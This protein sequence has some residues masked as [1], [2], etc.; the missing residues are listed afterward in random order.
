MQRHT[1]SNR[2][3][4]TA[5]LCF[6]AV[7]IAV[8]TLTSPPTSAFSERKDPPQFNASIDARSGSGALEKDFWACDYAATTRGVFGSEAYLC[9]SNHE[10]L[11][12]TKFRGDFTAM[13]K[14]WQQNKAAE[15]RA[16]AEGGPVASPR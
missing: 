1:G 5:T 11:K 6:C 12:K 10:E 4:G 3:A 9:S 8:G 7:T 15:H 14:W 16:L 2:P 13:L